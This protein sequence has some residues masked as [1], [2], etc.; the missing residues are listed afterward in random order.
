MSGVSIKYAIESGSLYKCMTGDSPP[1]DFRIKF[2]S[3]D[4]LNIKLIGKPD[5]IDKLYDLS[6]GDFLVLTFELIS[7]YKEAI[8]SRRIHDDLLLVDQDGFCYK[9]SLDYHLMYDSNYSSKFVFHPFVDAELV[10][11]IKY[12]GAIPFYVPKEDHAEY[13]FSVYRGSIEEI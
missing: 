1:I 9:K 10:P 6:Q 2:A 3:L 7:L 13:R 5:K 11:K 12:K 8:S 4:K